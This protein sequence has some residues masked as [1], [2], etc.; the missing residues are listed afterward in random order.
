MFLFDFF[1][2]LKGNIKK[3]LKRISFIIFLIKDLLDWNKLNYAIFL[4]E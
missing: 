4:M 1:K 2:G 3:L